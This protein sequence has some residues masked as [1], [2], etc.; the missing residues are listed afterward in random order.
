MSA[1]EYSI[2]YSLFLENIGGNVWSLLRLL[3]ISRQYYLQNQNH[4]EVDFHQSRW[5]RLVAVGVYVNLLIFNG[6]LFPSSVDCRENSGST[7]H[8]L[9]TVSM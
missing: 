6:N 1:T 4:L 7:G 3:A 9:N 8:L 5:Q 2:Q